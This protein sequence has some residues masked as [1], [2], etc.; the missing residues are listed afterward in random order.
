MAEITPE[1]CNALRIALNRDGE[2]RFKNGAV[3][4]QAD[5]DTLEIEWHDGQTTHVNR[6]ADDQIRQAYEHA[7]NGPPEPET[8][9]FPIPQP[10]GDG[11]RYGQDPPF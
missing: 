3:I 2:V 10:K 5:S 8:T 9:L 1:K 7:L 4:T 11:E 6:F